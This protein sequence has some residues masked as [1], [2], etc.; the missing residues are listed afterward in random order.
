VAKSTLQL[1]S[2]FADRARIH[3]DAEEA[4][5]QI[6][7]VFIVLMDI[8]GY[9]RFITGHET[10]LLHAEKIITELMEA[11]IDQSDYPLKL[12]KL[13]GDAALFY[14]LSDGTAKAAQDILG[15]I[16]GAFDA[17]YAREA[18]MAEFNMCNCEGC[19]QIRQLD[20]KAIVH[21]G[22]AAIKSIRRFEELAGGEVILAHRLLKNSITKK[23]YLLM[24]D[25]F[26][27]LLGGMRG[28]LVETRTEQCEGI[29]PVKVHVQY[30][31][32]HLAFPPPPTGSL[33]FSFTKLPQFLRMQSH[34]L[35]RALGWRGTT[36]RNLPAWP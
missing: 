18:R 26:F 9:T 3:A 36:F 16:R 8:S 1:N 20:L 4:E 34:M 31:E 6:H 27:T 17:F 19:K 7:Q 2:A 12:N 24:S 28:E 35:L 10:S 11:V 14:A 23:E 22:E 32:H 25:A 13:E 15:Q 30:P 5:M 33:R 29:G 21:H